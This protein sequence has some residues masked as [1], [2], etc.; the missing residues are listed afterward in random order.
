MRN[1]PHHGSGSGSLCATSNYDYVIISACVV[2]A[3]A[4]PFATSCRP[5]LVILVVSS[6]KTKQR[7]INLWY[8][9][10]DINNNNK[11]FS[12]ENPFGTPMQS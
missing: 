6:Q 1:E 2:C 12:F 11:L 5:Y 3:S 7:S 9:T 10:Y 4:Q 8:D